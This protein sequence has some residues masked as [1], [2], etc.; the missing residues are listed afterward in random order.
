[1]TLP[2]GATGTQPEPRHA[3]LIALLESVN[4]WGQ[5][6]THSF[7]NT[8]TNGTDYC[9]HSPPR[10]LHKHNA[11]TAVFVWMPGTEWSVAASLVLNGLVRIV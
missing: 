10:L 8:T 1:M 5:W 2:P 3:E 9:T 11:E 6:E 4:R 7:V